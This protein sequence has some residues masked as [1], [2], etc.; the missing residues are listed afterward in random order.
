MR[1]KHL[2]SH[3]VLVSFPALNQHMTLDEAREEIISGIDYA[4]YRE[5]DSSL[6]DAE[7]NRLFGSEHY[8]SGRPVYKT[9]PWA[10]GLPYRQQRRQP[11]Y[12]D[13]PKRHIARRCAHPRCYHTD[14]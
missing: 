9:S 10:E 14:L 11:H 1:A 4:A 6:H 5:T 2:F 12:Q 3:R 13:L 7:K 8:K